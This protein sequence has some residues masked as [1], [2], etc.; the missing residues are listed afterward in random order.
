LSLKN[1]KYI[2]KTCIYRI[3]KLGIPTALQ[4]CM[5]AFFAM[6]IGRVISSWGSVS[7]AVQKVGSQIEAISWM[8]AEGFAA[9]LTAFVGQNYGANRWDRILKGYK[10]TMIMAIV[11]GTFSTILLVFAGERVFSMFIPELEAISQGAV[12]LKILGYSQLFMC[13][14]ITT[15]GAFSG[16]GNT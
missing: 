14:E 13:I 15:A 11:V 5:F 9:A 6:V 4:N 16:L 2:D 7:I 10:A 1:K 3:C 12:Y 8:T